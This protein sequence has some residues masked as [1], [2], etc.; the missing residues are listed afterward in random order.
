M[1]YFRLSTS[2]LTTGPP[3][4]YTQP[5]SGLKPR[6]QAEQ[7]SASL[8][9]VSVSEGVVSEVQNHG[10]LFTEQPM[11]FSFMGAD[12][13]SYVCTLF[14]C[15]GKMSL[16]FISRRRVQGENV[17]WEMAFTHSVIQSSVESFLCYLLGTA[18]DTV[19]T[20]GDSQLM[21]D[22]K[23]LEFK[24]QDFWDPDYLWMNATMGFP[25]QL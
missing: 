12:S 2:G 4:S 7:G 23:H 5:Q 3:S 1:V 16:K 15:Y 25:L 18:A 10:G 9:V 24:S 20:L 14:W 11:N 8:N 6:H 17:S 22:S 19:P 21:L 13:K